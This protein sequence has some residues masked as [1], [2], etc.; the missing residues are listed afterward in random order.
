MTLTT[1]PE[2][3]AGNSTIVTSQ[4]K[5]SPLIYGTK[6]IPSGRFPS[7]RDSPFGSKVEL[8]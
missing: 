4:T 6:V 2:F 3:F 1:R 5:G 7:S 8:T